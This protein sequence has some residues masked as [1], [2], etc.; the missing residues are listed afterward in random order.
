MHTLDDKGEGGVWDMLTLAD[1]GGRMGLTNN[2]RTD[3]NT[4]KRAYIYFFFLKLVL[5]CL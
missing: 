2:D 5:K 4:V 3:K 1:K